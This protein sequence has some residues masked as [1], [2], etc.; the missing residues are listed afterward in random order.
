MAKGRPENLQPV[1]SK[2]EAI[3]RGQVGGVKSGESRRARK[4][5]REELLLL[6]SS[7]DWQE[8][9]T[10]ALLA[11]A[12]RGDVKAL[13]V[14]RDTIGEKPTDKRELTYTADNPF[15]LELVVVDNPT[16]PDKPRNK[17]KTDQSE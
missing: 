12:A 16:K 7:G 11:K 17:A 8:R 13:E 5:L 4:T 10:T 9:I 2:A 1:R 15:S 3:E 14:L 6:L